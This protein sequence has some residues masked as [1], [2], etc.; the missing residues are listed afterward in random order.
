MGGGGGGKSKKSSAPPQAQPL[1]VGS[2]MAASSAAATQQIKEQYKSL[3][4][5]Y[6]ALEAL[7]LGTADTIAGRLGDKPNPVY[8]VR[9]KPDGTYE[10]VQVGMSAPNQQTI[11]AL[12]RIR[13]GLALGDMDPDASM[14]T[15]IE[16]S[17]YDQG[18]RDLALGRSLSAEQ[19]RAAQQSAR[20][21]FSARGLGTSLGSSAA[22]ILNRDAAASARER[23]R[24]GFAA[25]ANDQY[26]GNV[27]TRRQALGNLYFAGAQNLMAADPYERAIDRGLNYSG[28][29]QGRQMA[30]AGQTFGSANQLAGQVA[31]FNSN[32]LESRYNS[33]ANNNAA[34]RAAGMQSSAMNRAATMGMIGNIGSS[35]FSDKRMKQDIKPLG[36]AGK[37]LGLTAY[38]FSYKGD[39]KKHRGF[40]AQD[41]QKVLPE[42]VTEVDYKGKKR[43]AIKPAVIGAA[44]VEELM[45]AKAA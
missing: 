28:G 12:A 7:S 34:M 2:I 40:M 43:L 16:Q 38:E 13:Q 36:K 9:V 14:P 8:E 25:A 15:S 41:V 17:L 26:I 32:M 3:I 35:I 29:S 30:M 45:T 37:V 11:D 18:E 22:E 39:D 33:W 4:E 42:A 20:A 21:A 19:E 10:R 27:A 5:N 24:Q 23:E 6:P 44:L 1:D 31:S